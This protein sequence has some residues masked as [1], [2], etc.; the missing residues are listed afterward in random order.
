[1]EP[2][3]IILEAIRDVFTLLSQEAPKYL[4]ITWEIFKTW[5]WVLLPLLLWKPFLSFWLWWKQENWAKEIKWVLLEIRPPK[6]VLKLLRSMENIFSSLWAVYSPA[7]WKEKWFQ[8]KFLLSFSFEIVSLG[9]ETHFFIRTPETLRNLVESAIYSQ[10]PKAEI[11]LVD[12][13][14][15]YVPQDIPNRDWDLWGAD[16]VM[17]KDDVYPIKTYSVFF[18]ERPEIEEEKRIDPL[19]Q[20]LEGMAKLQPGEQLWVQIVAKP[21]TNDEN[22]YKDRGEAEIAKL[23]GRPAKPKPKPIPL[24]AAEVIITGKPPGAPPA[25]K[26]E[27]PELTAGKREILTGIEEKISKNCFQSNIRFL[28][29]AKRDV[30]FSPNVKLPQGFFSQFT[31]INGLKPFGKTITSIQYFMITRRTYLRKRKMFR[32]YLDR[33]TPAF[34]RPGG[35]FVLNTEELATLY[36]IPGRIAVPA[37]FVPRIEAKKGEAPP[38]LPTE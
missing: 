22:N 34:P 14:S 28:Y 35:T 16:Y 10:Y 8:G 30:F 31:G 23:V 29:L 1:M 21:I 11:S 37:P 27:A 25:A 7:N 20:L 6:E 5:W 2:L 9:G 3:T 36:H 33:S 38:G 4:G 26:P 17:L 19:A 24:E 18:E 15:E 32:N 12:D 13:Y